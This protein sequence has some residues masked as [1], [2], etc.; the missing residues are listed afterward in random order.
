MIDPAWFTAGAATVTALVALF[1]AR[2]GL[3]Q[4]RQVR[5]DSRARS[6]PMMAAELRKPPYTRGIQDLVIGNY[7]QSLARNVKVTFDPP[8]PDPL[9]ERAA[10]SVSPFITRRYAEPI[11]V[12]TPGMQLT[13]IWFSG[14]LEDD[15]WVNFDPT[16]DQFTVTIAYDGPDD[17][18]YVDDFPLDVDLIRQHTYAA[19]SEAPESRLKEGVK[20]LAKIEKAVTRIAGNA[21]RP[22]GSDTRPLAANESRATLGDR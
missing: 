6:R 16:P 11:P 2:I 20:S 9:P 14:R 21:S 22:G 18:H 13:N 10:Q 8:I 12:A 4:L 3:S 19:S 17:T 1:T 15:L 7:G 5:A